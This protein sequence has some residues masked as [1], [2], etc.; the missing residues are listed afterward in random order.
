MTITF[1]VCL[2]MCLLSLPKRF[3]HGWGSC[4]L[5]KKK[6]HLVEGVEAGIHWIRS[7]GLSTEENQEWFCRVWASVIKTSARG[8]MLSI[9]S[10]YVMACGSIASVQM[11]EP[12]KFE[13]KGAFP[14]SDTFTCC[15]KMQVSRL[16]QDQLIAQELGSEQL[17]AQLCKSS[18]YLTH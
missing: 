9:Y 1:L 14:F 18:L 17:S 12:N 5:E 15:S 4:E 3:C 13:G 7:F 2:F 11:A 6:E 8:K 16:H 10:L